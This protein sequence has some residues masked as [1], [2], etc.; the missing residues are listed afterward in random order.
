MGTVKA[1]LWVVEVRDSRLGVW[2][3]L[4]YMASV[5]RSAARDNQKMARKHW[6][7]TRIVKYVREAA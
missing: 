1:V 6:R 3:V 5:G 7:F 2:E 4:D